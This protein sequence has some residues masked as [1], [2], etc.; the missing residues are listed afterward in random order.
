M[1]VA[2]GGG[3]GGGEE[4]EKAIVKRKEN[5]AHKTVTKQRAGNTAL[6]LRRKQ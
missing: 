4:K 2:A 5:E 1:C 3:G 6:Y